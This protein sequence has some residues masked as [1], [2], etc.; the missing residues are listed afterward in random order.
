MSSD[1]IEVSVADLTAALEGFRVA[2][3]TLDYGEHEGPLSDPDKVAEALFATLSANAAHCEP[4]PGVTRE[5]LIRALTGYNLVI[6]E[7]SEAAGPVTWPR[8]VAS[9][10]MERMGEP[11]AVTHAYEYGDAE[12]RVI[13]VIAE[14]LTS[15]G[16][17]DAVARVIRYLADRYGSDED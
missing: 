14:A 12:L 9:E 6:G 17:P 5:R 7:A 8:Q 3:Q 4:E 1:R 11:P 10:L 15:L 2:V 16:D 13:A